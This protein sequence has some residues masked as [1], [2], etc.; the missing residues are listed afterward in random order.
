AKAILAATPVQQVPS[1]LSPSIEER[2]DMEEE[3]GCYLTSMRIK[4]E[5][6][7]DGWKKA[8]AQ[9]NAKMIGGSTLR[10]CHEKP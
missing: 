8:V 4:C 2:A 3:F 1:S 10:P 7:A 6:I 9:A 5:R